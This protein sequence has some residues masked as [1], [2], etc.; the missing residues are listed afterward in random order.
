MGREAPRYPPRGSGLWK[1]RIFFVLW[2]TALKRLNV[3]CQASTDTCF[4]LQH[5][6]TFSCDV[7]FFFSLVC[8]IIQLDSHHFKPRARVQI[9][10]NV[11]VL[12]KIVI[13]LCE[14]ILKHEIKRKAF[15]RLKCSVLLNIKARLLTYRFF[16]I[17]LFCF[18]S[19]NVCSQ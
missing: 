19:F 6:F 7:F 12:L 1:N 17:E 18:R 9:N 14:Y 3:L 5:L 4:W 16:L 11:T 15:L 10:R 13:L 8:L 2:P